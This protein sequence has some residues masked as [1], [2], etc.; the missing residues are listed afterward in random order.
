MT[1]DVHEMQIYGII[2]RIEDAI[3]NSP[4]PK[5]GGG[6]GSKRIV[7]VDEIVDLLGDLKVTIPDDIR[8]ANGVIIEAQNRIDNASQLAQDTVEAARQQS[9][10]MVNEAAN[11]A[12]QIIERAKQ[13]YERL[14]SED[15]IYQEAQK[16]AQ[17]LAMKAE[18]SATQVYENAKVYADEILEDMERFLDQYR[19]LV[20]INR[21]DLGAR[22]KDPLAQK[23]VQ[24]E[25]QEPLGMEWEQQ[26]EAQ[27]IREEPMPKSPQPKSHKKP[28]LP[29]DAL[30]DEMNDDFDDDLDDDEEDSSLFSCFKRKKKTADKD[31]FDG[32]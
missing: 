6:Q 25:R 27:E 13:E 32:E 19:Q 3:E 30:D 11:K 8:R 1:N 14:V 31:D 7:D 2:A 23:N 9:E 29:P 4:K 5:L 18:Y 26:E 10:S 21:K 24:P 12:A 22:R 28:A 15:E 20:S 16:R 17:L